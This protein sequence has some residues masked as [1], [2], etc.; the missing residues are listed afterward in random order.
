MKVK[1]FS[2]IHLK[3]CDLIFFLHQA[4]IKKRKVRAAK[5]AALSEDSRR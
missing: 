2:A 5:A 3:L 4:L 1:N